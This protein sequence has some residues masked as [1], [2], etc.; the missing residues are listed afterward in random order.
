MYYPN[1]FMQTKDVQEYREFAHGWS[2]ECTEADKKHHKY[3]GSNMDFLGGTEFFQEIA[4]R[5]RLFATSRII[6]KKVHIRNQY[7]Q[8]TPN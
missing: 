6:Q 5:D 4:R 1:M 7:G 8:V 3:C 2:Q